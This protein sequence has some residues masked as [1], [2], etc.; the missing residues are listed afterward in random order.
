MRAIILCGPTAT[1][2]SRVALHIGEKIPVEIISAD[3]RLIYRGME[4][5]VDKPS[6]KDRSKV[7]HWLID[8]KNPDEEYSVAEYVKDFWECFRLITEKGKIP[9]VVGGTMLYIRAILSGYDF[10]KS[11]PRKELRLQWMAEEKE[12]PGILYQKLKERNPERARQLSPADY[13]RIIRALETEHPP[14]TVPYPYP[15]EFTTFALVASRQWL[16]QQIN[17]RVDRM[18]ERGLRQE[19]E[20]LFSQYPPFSPAFRSHGYQELIPFFEGKISWE[21]AIELVKQ[22]T[23]THAK[24]QLTWLKQI[25]HIPI[26]VEGKTP[27]DIAE[28]ILTHFLHGKSPS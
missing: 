4:I 5:G 14:S 23:R 21:K 24:H 20:K 12:H 25:P 22:H 16:Y 26:N 8:I 3:S 10:G 27:Q 9:L 18:V 13:P 7:P 2:K 15:A 19:V 11:P 17:A 28:E 1:G 6:L